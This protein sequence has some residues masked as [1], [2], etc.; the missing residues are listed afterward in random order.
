MNWAKENKF[1]T[2]YGIVMLIG[3]GF[4]GYKVYAASSAYDDASARY[5]GAASSYKNFRSQNPYP[6]KENLDLLNQ[7]KKE[8]ADVITAFQAGLAKREF[9]LEPMD[10]PTFQDKLKKAVD[11][12]KARA[13]VARVELPK[14]KF[15]LGFERYE[16]APPDQGASAL[17]GRDLK[18]IQWVVDQLIATPILGLVSIKRVEIPEEHSGARAA[19][20][21]PRPGPAG[22]GARAPKPNL[23]SSHS[24]DIVFNCRQ[25]Q[26]AKFLNTIVSPNA[27]QFYIIR[28]IKILNSN[29][30]APARAAAADAQQATPPPAGAP[31]VA[32]AAPVG[33]KEDVHL[34]VGEETVNV[35]IHV[36]IVDFAEP[37]PV[38]AAA[39]PAAK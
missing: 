12:V 11:E 27:P 7:Q 24:V 25:H 3:V 35:A 15:Y 8:A 39:T 38:A 26:L 30:K 5:S 1:L 23:V 19:A 20:T 31:V 33:P 37:T 29:P 13:G 14:D 28:T 21:T 36:E 34:L 22:P 9:P 32:A 6:N 2:G 16:T 4:L 18:A 17:L 10:P